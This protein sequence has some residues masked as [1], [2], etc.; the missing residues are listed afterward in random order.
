MNNNTPCLAIFL[1]FLLFLTSCEKGNE[2]QPTPDTSTSTTDSTQTGDSLSL[3]M[4]SVGPMLH[5]GMIQKGPFYAGTKISVYEKENTLLPTGRIF[6]TQTKDNSGRFEL[7]TGPLVSPLIK[8]EA[9][10]FF[11]NEVRW[12][13]SGNDLLLTALVDVTASEAL[14]VNIL[15]HLEQHRVRHLVGEGLSFDEA[16]RQALREILEE[17]FHFHLPYD[18]PVPLAETLNLARYEAYDAMLLSVSCLFLSANNEGG[19]TRLPELM[20]SFSADLKE[21]GDIDDPELNQQ[22]YEALWYVTHN[23]HR[24]LTR[25]KSHLDQAGMEHNISENPE[26]PGLVGYLNQFEQSYRAGINERYRQLVQFPAQTPFGPNLLAYADGDTIPARGLA[27]MAEVE[28]SGLGVEVNLSA[29]LGSR[30]NET[31]YQLHPDSW[32]SERPPSAG[33]YTPWD[34]EYREYGAHQRLLLPEG[35]TSAA[36]RMDFFESYVEGASPRVDVNVKYTG[37]LTNLNETRTLYVAQP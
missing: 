9:E 15:T 1:A 13:R 34:T 16:K 31:R 12:S 6:T 32:I 17:V 24:I 21:D 14:N 35:A 2:S 7:Q 20:A 25:L 29:R 30:D 11:Y 4:D 5:R 3:D 23:S 27:V 28:H 8:V 18:Q 22:L 36:S 19:R 37:L 10:G 33:S 26:H